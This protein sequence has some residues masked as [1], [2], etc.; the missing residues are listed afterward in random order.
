LEVRHS[1]RILALFFVLAVVQCLL[2]HC[3]E[4]QSAAGDTASSSGW[5]TSTPEEQGMSSE[6]LADLLENIQKDNHRIRSVTVIRNGHVVADACFHPFQPDTWHIIHSCTKSIMSALIGIAL[7][8]GY[9]GSLDKPVLDFFPEKIPRYL[10]ERKKAITLRHLLTMSSGLKT[11]DSYLYQWKGLMEMGRSRDWVQYIL[12]LPMSEAP[13]TRFE[14][15]NCVAFLLSA[16]LQKTTGKNALS[17]AREHLFAPLGVGDVD[18]GFGQGGINLGWGGIRMKPHDVAKIGLTYLN[19]GRWNGV[20]VI[21]EAWVEESTRAQ[22]RSGTLSDQ[23]GYQWWVDDEG[24]YMML[25][26]GGQFV[27]VHPEKNMVVV[28]ASVLTMNEFFTPEVLFRNFIIPAVESPEPLPPNPRGVARLDSLTAVVASP[29]PEKV[30]PFPEMAGRISGKTYVFDS[31]PPNFKKFSLTFEPGRDE[32]EYALSFGHKNIKVNMGLDNVYRVTHSEG[33]FRAYRGYWAND[34]TF[35]IDYEVLDFTERGGTRLVFED[36][37]V[38][39]EIHDVIANESH[40][41][42]GR[43]QE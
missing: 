14:Y 10:D 17:F 39:V 33:Y 29:E 23:Y 28:F 19:K 6:R 7:E 4:A 8:E 12:D 43:L 27:I 15:S 20:Q 1:F 21:P 3:S 41:L 2:P 30:S 34:R 18:W 26:Y 36:D 22:I 42:I 24:Y 16:I 37:I 25:G 32:A 5:L 11:E 38:K 35:L 40:E 9:I 31:N 13:G